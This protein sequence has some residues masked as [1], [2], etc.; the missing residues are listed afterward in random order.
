MDPSGIIG[1]IG[2]AGHI[3]TTCTK[4]GLNWR[5][6]PDDAKKL[7]IEVESLH[8]TLWETYNHLIQ[9]PDFISAF[10][11]KHS[12][13]LS[14]A[15]P[16]DSDDS[17]L[18]ITCKQELDD[19]LKGLQ[20][21]LDGSRFGRERL[22]ATVF[23]E[24]TESAIESLQRRC[25]VINN[26]ISID[27]ARLAANT[28][29]EV[30]STRKHLEERH[31]DEKKK[32]IL[33]WITPIDFAAQQIDNLE[34]R[35]EGTGL[36]FL[37]S[38]EFQ[39]W[40]KEDGKILFCPGM[41]G[42]G[43]TMLTSIVIEHL[44]QKFGEDP[45]V[46]VTYLFCNFRR[47]DELKP[48]GLLAS[49][50]KQLYLYMPA[51]PNEVA[52]AYE[53]HQGGSSLLGLNEIANVNCLATSRHIPEIETY[54][55]DTPSVEIRATDE[56]VMEFLDG[57]MYKLPQAVRKS[58]ELQSE[59]KHGIVRAVQGMFLLA[60]LYLDSLQ[61]KRSA[62]SIKDALRKLASGSSAYTN[63]YDEAME[64]IEGQLEDQVTLA[65]DTLSWIVYA[66]RPLKTLELQHALAIE[67]G[68]AGLDRENL[69]ELEDI[70]SVCA[71]LVTVDEESGIIRLVHYTTQEY[72]ERTAERWLPNAKH[73]IVESCITYLSF[74]DFSSGACRNNMNYRLKVHPLYEQANIEA[75][76]EVVWERNPVSIATK[77]N[78]P[79]RLSGL[80]LAAYFG[81]KEAF[82]TIIEQSGTE[83][84]M[85]VNDSYNYPPLSYAV[86]GGN[87]D[88]IAWLL[89]INEIEPNLESSYNGY[90]PIS[91][92]VVIGGV[93]GILPFI[94]SNR[95]EL[96]VK[97]VRGRT[98]L[99]N[100]ASRG[101]VEIVKAF[102]ESQKVDV[103]SQTK[104]GKTPLS[105][106]AEYGHIDVVKFLLETGK[107]NPNAADHFGLTP[108]HY[109]LNE[110]QEEIARCLLESGKADASLLTR[111]AA[112]ITPL[113]EA[114]RYCGPEHSITN[115]LLDR[116]EAI[117]ISL[118][119]AV[120]AE[121]G[122]LVEL[123]GKD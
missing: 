119:S 71:G 104:R 43:K 17:S 117:G 78:S 2:V 3:I 85:N 45:A 97:D 16:S 87:A 63:A 11:G 76:F 8:K 29:I 51:G 39:S 82:T 98:P 53:K 105:L 75:A 69:T 81:L 73:L 13:V 77:A 106:A 94:E 101:Y 95:A 50:L 56:D 33:H 48:R 86:M 114:L 46:A 26:M 100:A 123:R 90:A 110:R 31:F 88:F 15:A 25:Q 10:E 113:G 91:I 84:D 62:K 80:H 1:I 121:E 122:R 83:I 12:A 112:G 64:R 36:W 18:L 9:N 19:V 115:L 79:T 34:R 61:G 68:T 37:D 52:K 67:I 35:Q 66:R 99:A 111:G 4:L 41:P 92:A 7:K 22:K 102:V 120:K 47:H 5:Y 21:R 57:Q 49:I 107:V 40:V 38:P 42:A 44:Q 27:N 14:E 23:G 58:K 60:Q 24:R 103:E 30:R 96:D 89:S 20:K 108:L 59:V 118:E 116:M 70:G 72:F 6:A 93:A 32:E 28:N 109:A 65:K 54:F 74:D 55:E